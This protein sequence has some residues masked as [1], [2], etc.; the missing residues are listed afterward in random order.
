MD[1]SRD[2]NLLKVSLWREAKLNI[3]GSVIKGLATLIPNLA[4]ANLRTGTEGSVGS[5]SV[6]ETGVFT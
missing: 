3:F 6:L 4:L 1:K 5:N 2:K